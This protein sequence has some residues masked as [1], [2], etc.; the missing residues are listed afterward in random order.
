[1]ISWLTS[2]QPYLLIRESRSFV[3]Q[4]FSVGF[5]K[6]LCVTMMVLVVSYVGQAAAQDA[7]T[8]SPVPQTEV[9][10]QET[11]TINFD[12]NQAEITRA[13][14]VLVGVAVALSLGLVVYCWH[15]MPSRRVRIASKRLAEQ[16]QTARV[17]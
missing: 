2:T 10:T 6:L 17:S 16:R 9:E 7:P 3:V 11:E 8:I 13:R 15:T 1:M 4:V 5:M 12:K 14:Y